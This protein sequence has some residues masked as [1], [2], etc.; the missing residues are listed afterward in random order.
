MNE[1]DLGKV[2]GLEI[3]PRPA[4]EKAPDLGVERK[5]DRR[6]HADRRTGKAVPGAPYV[7]LRNAQV[8]LQQDPRWRGRLRLNTFADQVEVD[9]NLLTDDDLSSVIVWMD[10]FYQLRDMDAKKVQ[11]ALR[12]VALVAGRYHPLEAYLGGLRWDGQR[13]VDGW[14]VRYLGAADTPLV[15]ALGKCFLVSC[16]ARALRPACKVD[17]VLVLVGSQGL[18]KSTALRTLACGWF[19]DTTLDLHNKDGMAALQGIW[20]YELAELDELQRR[21]ASTIKAFLSRQEDRYRPSYGI[22]F[23]TRKRQ[24]VIV[25]STNEEEFISDPTGS[26]RF[27]PVR[28]GAG[29]P[30]DIPSIEADRDQL[31]AEALTLFHAGEPW[32]LDKASESA[33]KEASEAHRKSDP[34]EERID[35]WLRSHPTAYGFSI[36]EILEAAVNVPVDKQEPRQTSRVGGILQ[37]LGYVK[38]RS[39][40][41]GR[42]WRWFPS[43]EAAQ[44]AQQGIERVCSPALGE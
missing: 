17:T 34:W 18:Q 24:T 13:R 4:A 21:D 28:A 9:G 43:R 12:H 32:W 19:Q 15:R 29:G 16:I 30:I 5:L 10:E 20:I 8:I 40:S 25:G 37:K 41:W 23:V 42:G 36:G 38:E 27:W 6:W 44:Q 11:R 26:R 39:R 14:M 1:Q 22:N 2:V 3:E 7:T 31:W 33:L 35:A